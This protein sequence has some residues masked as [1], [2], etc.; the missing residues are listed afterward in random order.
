MS[1]RITKEIRIPQL[2]EGLREVRVVQLLHQ[3]GTSMRRGSPLYVVETD[4]TTVQL[5]V[6]FDATLVQW[7]AQPGDVVSINSIV[8]I[9]TPS[10]VPAAQAA[11]ERSIPPRTRAYARRFNIGAEDLR[12]IA[13]SAAKVMPSD[14]DAFLAHSSSSQAPARWT[15]RPLSQAHRAF[16]FR[17]RRSSSLVIAASIS[18]V[19]RWSDLAAF[20][21]LRMTP[22]QVFA[23]AVAD[24]AQRHPRFR[25]VMVGDDVLREFDHANLGVAV[26]RP[27]DELVIATVREADTIARE[28]WAAVFYRQLRRAV[29]HEDQAGED[30]QILLTH[31]GVAHV[32]NAVPTLVAP[33]SSIFFLGA[34]DDEGRVN[35]TVTFDHRL[36]NG[37][38]AARFLEDLRTVVQDEAKRSPMNEP[39]PTSAPP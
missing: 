9:V 14:I 11:T 38:G 28:E 8:A 1:D 7:L 24:T 39:R 30:T 13:S 6:P 19:L 2:G 4:K 18:S 37:V 22:F 20:Q 17:L 10:G 27:D 33:A 36:I 25:S 31:L 21:F 15:D 3:P 5:E 12:K 32:R 34:P 29:R 16:I 23:K 35:V 26:A